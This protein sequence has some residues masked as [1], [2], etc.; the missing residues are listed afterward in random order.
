MNN[1]VSVAIAMALYEMQGSMIHDDESGVL[2][3]IP[4]KS[5][6]CVPQQIILRR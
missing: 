3:I 4:R 1:E 2:T 6:W 5:P